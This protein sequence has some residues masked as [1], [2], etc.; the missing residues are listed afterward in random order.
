MVTGHRHSSDSLTG[1]NMHC[2]NTHTCTY[3]HMNAYTHTLMHTHIHTDTYADTY[4]HAHICPCMYIHICTH[5][6]THKHTHTNTAIHIHTHMHTCV[7]IYTHYKHTHKYTVQTRMHPTHDTRPLG[8]LQHSCREHLPGSEGPKTVSQA[9]PVFR[10]PGLCRLSMPPNA[11]SL[12]MTLP[13]R[14]ER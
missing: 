6:N 7:Y 10:S 9:G 2:E 8:R 5:I 3:T 1:L 13:R 11:C 12:G 4:T 14:L